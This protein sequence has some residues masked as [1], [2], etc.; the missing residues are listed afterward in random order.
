M[1]LGL[2]YKQGDATAAFL[3]AYLGK[4]QKVFVDMPRGFEVK[5]KNGKN[6]VLRLNKNLYGLRQ[7]PRAFWK[8]MTSKME[9]CG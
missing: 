1:L 2:K 5:G 6:K 4:D 9:L 7:S 3:H 8:Y